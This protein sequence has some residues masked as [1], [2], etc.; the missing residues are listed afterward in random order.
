MT[1]HSLECDNVCCILQE[2]A[3]YL[4]SVCASVSP[5]SPH[6]SEV[7]Q[8]PPAPGAHPQLM[9][10]SFFLLSFCFYLNPKMN[11]GRSGVTEHATVLIGCYQI[12]LRS[13]CTAVRFCLYLIKRPATRPRPSPLL[14]VAWLTDARAI[15]WDLVCLSLIPTEIEVFLLFQCL[16]VFCF[17][18]FM[19]LTCSFLYLHDFRSL[20]WKLWLLIHWVTQ[21]F[22][23]FGARIFILFTLSDDVPEFLIFRSSD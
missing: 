7:S 19:Y 21:S 8:A 4:C 20:L 15:V 5:S 18:L 1:C 12:A 10:S 2:G 22:S 23:L 9:L 3:E 11:A 6:V 16:S 17:L 14:L 13:C